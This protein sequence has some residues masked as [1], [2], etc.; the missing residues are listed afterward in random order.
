MNYETVK[1]DKSMYKAEGGF[2]AQLER[3]DPSHKYA[4]TNLDS[5]DAYQRQL[6]RF[7][8]KVNGANSDT[9]SKFFSTSD[10]ATL[11]PE[12]ISRS[13]AQGAQ[14]ANLLEDLIAAKTEIRSMDYRSFYTEMGDAVMND[15][16]AEGAALPEISLQLNDHLVKM[17]K[18]GRILKASYEA[19]RFQHTDVFG[20]A[21]RQIGASIAKTQLHD[22]L[23]LIINGVN[24]GEA[25]VPAAQVIQTAANTVAYKDLM[26]L[27]QLFDGFEMNVLVASP[28]MATE[29]LCI[30]QF[31]GVYNPDHFDNTGALGTPLGAKLIK[32][33]ALAAGTVVALDKRYALEMVTSGG[34]QVEHDKLI[35]SQLERAAVTATYGFSKIFPG[36]AKVLKR[37]P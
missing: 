6:K 36:A 26:A 9:I 33:S 29:I 31:K 21:L 5:L 14:E 15:T 10:A 23:H 34:I 19:I 1:L 24:D 25:Q 4:G 2:S 8:I 30:D 18:R 20:V 35:D 7:G 32:S 17:V 13:V 37:R 11:F 12:Y 22:A 16:I 27:W 28:D 3:L